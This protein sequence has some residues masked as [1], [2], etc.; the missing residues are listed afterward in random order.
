MIGASGRKKDIVL[1]KCLREGK[2]G[3]QRLK[4]MELRFKSE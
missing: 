1:G 3:L 2:E 4:R